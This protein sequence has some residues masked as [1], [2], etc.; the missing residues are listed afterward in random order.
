M[1]FSAQRLYDDLNVTI[2]SVGFGPVADCSLAGEVLDATADIS[3]GTYQHSSNTS[4]LQLIYENISSV[5]N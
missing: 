1:N 3:N 2:F 4:E 5:S